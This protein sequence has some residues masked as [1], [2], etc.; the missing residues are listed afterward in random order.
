MNFINGHIEQGIFRKTRGLTLPSPPSA[1]PE[2]VAGRDLVYGV[3][4][5]HNIRVGADGPS[6]TAGVVE[7]NGLETYAKVDCNGEEISCLFRE[8][9]DMR[10][11]NPIDIVIAPVYIHLFDKATGRHAGAS[12]R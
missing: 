7:D 8:R 9:L 10:C 12:D 1:A 11:G 4:P 6:G 3:L 5:E 2:R